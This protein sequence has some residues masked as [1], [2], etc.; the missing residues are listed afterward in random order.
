LKARVPS[1]APTGGQP[2]SNHQVAA[3]EYVYL[4][5]QPILDRSGA[6]RAFELLFRSGLTNSARITD[7]ADATAQVIARLIG[8]MGLGAALGDYTGYVNVDRAVLMSD[9]VRLLPPERFVLEI[10]ETVV[11]DEAL[12]SR[13]NELRRW[14]FRLALD[15]VS[16]VSP[17][18]LA[19]L[20]CVDIV[21]IDFLE[22]PREL[23]AELIGTVRRH[24]KLLLAEKVE[25]PED[26]DAAM[27]AGFDLFQGYHF[28]KP[29]VLTSRR[30]ASSR[31]ALL[32]LLVLLSDEPEIFEL[33]VELKRIPN[34][35]IQLLR[36]L[37]SSAFRPARTI[38]SLREA[39]M[40]VGMRQITHWAQL[41]LFADGQIDAL[42]TNPL[43]QLCGTRARFME[44]AAGRTRPG[45]GRFADTASI[46]GVFSLVHILFGVAIE[47]IVATLPIH[48][49]IRRALLERQGE[50]GLLL[51][52][53]EAA[54]S[55]EQMPIRAACEALCVFTPNDLTMLGLAATAS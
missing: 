24:G 28:A 40:L 25:T 26:H 42:R 50:L 48:A 49:D 5:R 52:A 13:C 32:R 53:A 47:D 33:E 39:I 20:P 38:S 54:E 34:L 44:L 12:F 31:D 18:L 30:I 16:Q 11:F 37:N 2:A 27:R 15:D 55:G 43:V 1:P 6:L 41:L 14:G 3:P 19:F 17:S 29:Q 45:D 22:C 35:V 9:T 8:D 46:T 4:G 51:N 36:L 21:K 23:L 10:L 7:D